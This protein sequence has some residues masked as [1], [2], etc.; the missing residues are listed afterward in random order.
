MVSFLYYG[1]KMLSIKHIRAH[2]SSST[3]V[4]TVPLFALFQRPLQMRRATLPSVPV[5]VC[6][7]AF[8]LIAFTAITNTTAPLENQH[9][10]LVKP[11]KEFTA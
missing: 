7:A 2:V 8:Q 4:L 1:Q 6:V 3:T 11:E 9:R 10:S 5:V